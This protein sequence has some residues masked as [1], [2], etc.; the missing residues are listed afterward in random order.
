MHTSVLQKLMSAFGASE[1]H[2]EI[3]KQMSTGLLINSVLPKVLHQGNVYLK[4]L[5]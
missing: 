5:T 1:H 3:S 4:Y 2:F